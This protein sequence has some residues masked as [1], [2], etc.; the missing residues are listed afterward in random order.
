V[1]NHNFKDPNSFKERSASLKPQKLELKPYSQ[2]PNH[3]EM[4]QNHFSF[5]PSG[6]DTSKANMSYCIP[7]KHPGRES[8]L[9]S[10]ENI[11]PNSTFEQQNTSISY[12]E[13]PISARGPNFEFNQSSDPKQNKRK[14]INRTKKFKINTDNEIKIVDKSNIPVPYPYTPHDML[15]DSSISHLKEENDELS[16]IKAEN[17][18]LRQMMGNLSL[19]VN[20]LAS[21]LHKHMTGTNQAYSE[22]ATKNTLL[23]SKVRYLEKVLNEIQNN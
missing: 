14:S 6:L 19:T 8:L 13:R 11:H 10:K 18:E 23:E 21:E 22:L 16:K 3:S 17:K 5:K 9:H 2:N 7:P 12:K 20:L 1:V 4:L 15:S